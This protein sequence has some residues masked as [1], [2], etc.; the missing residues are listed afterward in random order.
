MYITKKKIEYIIAALLVVGGV[1]VFLS[2]Q[3]HPSGGGFKN[4]VEYANE[5]GKTW[6]FQN[7]RED[8]GLFVYSANPSTGEVSTQNNAI[9]QLMASRVLAQESKENPDLQELHHRNLDFI[10]EFWYQTNGQDGYVLYNDKSK[11]GANAMLLRTLVHGPFYKEYEKEAAAL[12]N[13]ILTLQDNTT[14][15]FQPWYVEPWYEYDQDYL[16]TFYSGEA[17]LA[18]VEYY[19]KITDGF[20]LSVMRLSNDSPILRIGNAMKLSADFYIDRYVTHLEENYYPAYVPWHTLALNKLYKSTGEGKYADAIF[21]LNDKLLELQDTGP[22]FTGRFYNP[23][24][25]QYGSPH[26]SSDAV[27]T[28]GLAY[29]YEIAKLAGDTEHEQRYRQ[30]LEIAFENLEWLQYQE[31]IPTFPV[32]PERYIGALRTKADSFWIRVDTTQHAVDA[33]TKLLDV[34]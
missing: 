19:E 10:F 14:G 2:Q 29:A 25:P 30:A 7:L 27:Y 13:G 21:V 5:L 34:L 26:A 31:E 9:R 16:L 28:E 8:K 17:L 12:A 3:T 1:F 4:R 20:D 23:E 6:I 18:L 15:E 32:E 11:L 22:G 24:T 33:F